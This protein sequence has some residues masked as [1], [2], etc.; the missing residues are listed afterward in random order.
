[1]LPVLPALSPLLPRGLLGGNCYAVNGSLG[2]ATALLAEA[3]TTGAW[4]AVVGV[5]EFGAEA[6]AAQGLNLSRTLL[7][8]HP[9]SEW[10]TV[11]ATLV[12]VLPI[13]LARPPDRLAPR[14][15]TRLEA[16]VR[17]QS[18]VFVVLQEGHARWPRVAAT[19]EAGPSEWATIINGRGVLGD[20]S[21]PVRVTERSG[22][23]R[24]LIL[25]QHA[26]TYTAGPAVPARLRA[27][28]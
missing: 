18:N 5:P 13:V 25:R 16:R 10:L 6:A 23:S 28:G 1:M 4:S 24:E 2:L 11:V 27:V 8:P 9:E 21:F 22:Q 19:I 20:R 17:D 3:S 26:G 12:D 15:I 14:E 7:V